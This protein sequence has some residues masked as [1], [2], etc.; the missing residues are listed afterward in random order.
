VHVTK[1]LVAT[2]KHI[3][4]APS[5]APESC[6][7]ISLHW[8]HWLTWSDAAYHVGRHAE[9]LL[10]RTVCDSFH[11][12]RSWKERIVWRVPRFTGPSGSG[13]QSN[14]DD[15]LTVAVLDVSEGDCLQ[16]NA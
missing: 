2:E 3:L 12:T 13:A 5:A 7:T 9:D 1:V 6:G 4:F 16:S 8:K 11:C 15:T 14:V 10:A